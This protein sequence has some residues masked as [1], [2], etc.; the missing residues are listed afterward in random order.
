MN[1]HE[2]G[3]EGQNRTADLRG[4]AGKRDKTTHGVSGKTESARLAQH[5][6]AGRVAP[7]LRTGGMSPLNQRQPGPDFC[8]V[9]EVFLTLMNTLCSQIHI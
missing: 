7:L 2:T 5:L 3:Q 9:G 1:A 4:E 8:P 6:S